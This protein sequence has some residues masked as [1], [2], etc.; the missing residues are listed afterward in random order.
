MAVLAVGAC[1]D[2]ALDPSGEPVATVEVAPPTATVVVGATVPLTAT[3]LDAAGNVVTGR[4]VLWVSADPNFATVSE[5]GIVTGKYVGTVP[6]A[7]SVEGK[8]ATAEVVV[9]PVPVASVRITPSSRDIVVGGTVRLTAEALDGHGAVLAG[10]PVAWTTSR[11]NVATVSGD[12]LVTGVSP[13]GVAI[14]A[15]IEGKSGVAAINVT[16]APVASVAV[17]PSSAT[18]VVGETTGF[19]AQPR[20]ASGQPLNGRAVSWASNRPQVASVNATGIVFAVA[21]GTATIIA[22]SEGKSG[23]ATVT[24]VAP[25]VQRVEVTPA[26]ATVDE[27]E[28]FRLT[29]TVYDSRGNV[30]IGRAVQWTSDNTRVATVDETGRVRGHRQGTATITATVDGKSGSA[31]VRVRDD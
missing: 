26:D 18:L 12:G 2:D 9:L 14:T 27:G 6:I 1:R 31:R 22:S 19:E 8:T 7:A 15:T 13:G 24:V 11:P 28:S 25:S 29:A 16:P 5:N 30:V 23:S 4:R 17:S 10:R 3:A 20:S 21:P